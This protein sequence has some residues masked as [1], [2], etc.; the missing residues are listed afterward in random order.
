MKKG[1]L[2]INT[3]RGEIVATLDLLNAINKGKVEGAGLDVIEGEDLIKEEKQ[4]LSQFDAKTIKKIEEC[5]NLLHNEKVVFTPHIAFYSQEALE[6][7]L[8]TSIDNILAFI[9]NKPINLVKNV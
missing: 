5:Y 4:A 1:V 7:I 8:H 9:R 3:S 2:L 6:R